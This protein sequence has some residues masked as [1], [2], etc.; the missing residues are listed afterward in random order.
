M[1]QLARLEDSYELK[2][3]EL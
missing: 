3:N 1:T 2:Q